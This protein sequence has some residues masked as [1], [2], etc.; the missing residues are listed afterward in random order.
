MEWTKPAF[1][2]S[3]LH[4]ALR[5]CRCNARLMLIKMSFQAQKAG[6]PRHSLRLWKTWVEAFHPAVFRTTSTLPVMSYFICLFFACEIVFSKPQT[7]NRMLFR[8]H[9]PPYNTCIFT[10]TSNPLRFPRLS[11]T[12]P[13]GPTVQLL[14]LP[15][16]QQLLQG[17]IAPL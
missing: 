9:C 16:Y 7:A 14:L 10:K 4:S 3:S 12:R 8:L 11:Q 15:C 6:V 13:R 5:C 2:L 17:R 1:A